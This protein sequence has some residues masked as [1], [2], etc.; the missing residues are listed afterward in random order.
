[1]NRSTPASGFGID[2]GLPDDVLKVRV[3]GGMRA[4]SGAKEKPRRSGAPLALLVPCFLARPS[5]APAIHAAQHK[6]AGR[7]GDD[8]MRP[9]LPPACPGESNQRRRHLTRSRPQDS[10]NKISDNGRPYGAQLSALPAF[11][12]RAVATPDPD[13]AFL[14]CLDA[15]G[16]FGRSGLVALR[17]TSVIVVRRTSGKK[18]QQ[19]HRGQCGWEWVHGEFL[20]ITGV[21]R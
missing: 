11:T 21:P 20:P 10:A 9:A 17:R 14:I 16:E 19:A 13:W 7:K 4:R 6:R 8:H 3:H 5:C 2:N 18:H 12:E 1:M 15:F